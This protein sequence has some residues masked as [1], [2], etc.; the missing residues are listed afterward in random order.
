MASKKP[1]KRKTTGRKKAPAKTAKPDPGR[2]TK[3]EY[4]RL[5]SISRT[6]LDKH[7]AHHDAPKRGP[8]RK[9]DL[10]DLDGFVA[11]RRT[12]DSRGDGGTITASRKELIDLQVRQAALKLAEEELRLVS[13]AEV[14]MWIQERI[15]AVKRKLLALPPRMVTRIKGKSDLE[16]LEI[17]TEEI[18]G[19]IEAAG[20]YERPGL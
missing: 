5:R 20:Q 11:Y 10:S 9:Y 15:G 1:G 13:L 7:L 8:D 17:L 6:A 4:M 16:A 2:V 19:V 18:T 14:T 3:A 12:L